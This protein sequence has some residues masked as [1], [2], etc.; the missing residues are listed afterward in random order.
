MAKNPLLNKQKIKHK[1]I[2]LPKSAGILDDYAVRKNISS[3]EGSVEHIP[4]EDNHII[5]KLYFDNH[6][7]WEEASSTKIQPKSHSFVGA[8]YFTS[9]NYQDSAGNN[10]LNFVSSKLKCSR[11]FI[12][13]NNNVG[14]GITTP[15]FP[16]DVVGDV[17]VNG[18]MRTKGP[19]Y[20]TGSDLLIND[21]HICYANG[22][23]RFT[24]TS[25]SDNRLMLKDGGNV[26]IGTQTPSAPLTIKKDTTT[27]LEL[28][29]TDNENVNNVFA[30]EVASAFSSPNYDYM[31]IGNTGQNNIVISGKDKVGIKLVNPISDLE[32]GGNADHIHTFRMDSYGQNGFEWRT[33]GTPGYTLDLNYKNPYNIAATIFGIRYTGEVGIGTTAPNARLHVNGDTLIEGDLNVTGNFM[34]NQ[35]YGEMGYHNHTGTTLTFPDTEWVNLYF[36]VADNLNGFSYTGGFMESSNL[37]CQVAGKYQAIYRLSGSGQNNHVYHSNVFVNNEINNE[38]CGDHKKMS[39]GGDIIPMGGSCFIDLNVGD[40]IS[41]AVRDYEGSGNGDYYSAVL[42]L[43]RIGD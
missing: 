10:L 25:V 35:I 5:N 38:L 6:T 20:F 39:A 15:D 37:T 1:F 8:T 40:N 4:T 24:E 11:D 30:I 16:L 2:N 13:E 21:W 43:V 34:G 36:T 31:S 19:L 42:N 41:V 27:M 17:R 26:G 22:G 12:V 33:S 14:I 3:K 29:R 32:I 28:D 23:L 7:F 9:N 18:K